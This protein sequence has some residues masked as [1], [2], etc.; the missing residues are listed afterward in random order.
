[1]S[2][3]TIS[4]NI[5]DYT[6][7]ELMAIIQINNDN[8]QPDNIIKKTDYY[9]HKYKNN[10]PTLAIFF[11]QIQSQLLQYADELS[12]PKK[13]P[14]KD[15]QNKIVVEGF[16]AKSNEAIYPVGEKQVSDWYENENLTQKDVNQTNKITDRKQKVQFFGNEHIP[17]N[18]EQIATTDTYNV[19]VKQGALNPNLKNTITRS[20]NLDS[21]FRQYTNGV[22]S[23][24]TDYTCDLSDTLKDTLNMRL[25]SYQIPYSWYV[26]DSAYGN[27][28]LWVMDSTT[29]TTVSVSVAPG[30]YSP[31]NFVTTL[32]TAFV[33]AGFLD[34]S[35][36]I[37]T[38]N[39]NSGNI[40]IQLYGIPYV[41]GV[42]TIFTCSLT[43][44]IMF[45]DFTGNLQCNNNCFSK[46]NHFFNN[47]LGWLMGYRLPY[48]NVVE[49]GC[50]APAVLDLS[51]TK[52]LILVI[53]DYNQNHINN[54]LVSITQ[55]SNALKIP[56]YYSSDLPFTC[57]T[58]Q[59]NNKSG[60]NLPEIIAQVTDQSLFDFQNSNPLNGLLVAGKYEEDYSPTQIILPSAPRTLT[61]SQ[62]YTINQINSNRN[63]LTKYLAKAPTSTD[64]LS[65]IP[66]KTSGQ[67]TGSLLVEFSG[68]L[69]DNIRTYFGPVN[70]ERMAVRL[71][72][73]KGNVLNL[74]GNDWCVT[75][76]VECLYEY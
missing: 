72:D 44:I 62:I 46:T 51:G 10:D 5:S 22:D 11:R 65:I 55:L 7:S 37:V 43:T 64:I 48:I 60:N 13:N 57:T 14:K 74:N 33:S 73:D 2:S 69:Q 68:S 59:P 34:P 42:D 56:D 9:Y 6:L 47:S 61:Q 4:T 63:N 24:S 71:L 70:I 29:D 40:T 26:I 12:T 45:Y 67:S 17:M 1:M 52:Y 8:F 20:L 21:Q 16:A 49:A 25:F 35:L 50:V 3:S 58:P 39:A 18:R 32:N 54:T 53:D 36:N 41:E 19:S 38:Y 23:G 66:I 30:N 28:C 27:T 76:I 15:L 31:A 75:L